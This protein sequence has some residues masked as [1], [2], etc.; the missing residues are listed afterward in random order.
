MTI[1]PLPLATRIPRMAQFDLMLGAVT[2]RVAAPFIDDSCAQAILIFKPRNSFDYRVCYEPQLV[3][4]S[5]DD[6]F[7]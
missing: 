2:T 5:I 4:Q 6:S 3:I 7:K 1:T